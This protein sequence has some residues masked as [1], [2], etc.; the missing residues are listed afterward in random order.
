MHLSYE[1]LNFAASVCF[2]VASPPMDDRTASIPSGPHC[3][4]SPAPPAQ[5]SHPVS[6]VCC[7]NK[8]IQYFDTIIVVVAVAVIVILIMV[9]A[10]IVW[11]WRQMEG[12]KNLSQRS[13]LCEG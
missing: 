2:Y 11:P 1:N 10:A 3:D 13:V 12:Y 5:A 4:G 7:C 6:C 9:I 8:V